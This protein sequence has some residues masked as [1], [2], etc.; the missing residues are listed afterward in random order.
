MSNYMKTSPSFS[1]ALISALHQPWTLLRGC[2]R[3]ATAAAHGLILV[4]GDGR[5]PRESDSLS[6]MSDP[7]WPHGL[8]M[9]FSRPEYWSWLPFPSP[10]DFPD[11]G[12][13]LGSPALQADTLPSELPNKPGKYPWQV[14]SCHWHVA[15]LALLPAIPP[16]LHFCFF[17]PLVSISPL[18]SSYLSSLSP[19]ILHYALDWP[20]NSFGFFCQLLW[21]NSN[22]LF[23]QPNISW[24]FSIYLQ[25]EY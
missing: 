22:D 21:K 5:C 24:F 9:E 23:G 1:K 16:S 17:L 20:Q 3:S 4:E 15:T 7:L 2:W 19:H 6:V 13:E 25:T 12:I 10:G 14:P 11:S 18:L 8:S